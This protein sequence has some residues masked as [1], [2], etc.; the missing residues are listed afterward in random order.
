[1][2]SLPENLGIINETPYDLYVFAHKNLVW[3][4][5]DLA[6]L[7]ALLVVPLVNLIEEIALAIEGIAFAEKMITAL[8]EI[9]VFLRIVANIITKSKIPKS[10]ISKLGF[11]VTNQAGNRY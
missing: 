5:A 1:M 10:M 6:A 11:I 3:T 7:L 9:I 2:Q 4:A 8:N